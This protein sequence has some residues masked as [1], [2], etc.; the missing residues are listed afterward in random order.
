[1]W[2]LRTLLNDNRPFGYDS[3]PIWVI[4]VSNYGGSTV[5]KYMYITIMIIFNFSNSLSN[6]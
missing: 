2:N 5:L 6:S 1:M 3:T 4:K